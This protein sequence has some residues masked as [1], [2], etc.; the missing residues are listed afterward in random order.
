M[1]I[2]KS[3]YIIPKFELAPW[4]GQ[5]YRPCF[6]KD[7]EYGDVKCLRNVGFQPDGSL[8]NPY[9]AKCSGLTHSSWMAFKGVTTISAIREIRKPAGRAQQKTVSGTWGDKKQK[10]HCLVPEETNNKKHCLVPEETKNTVWYLRG[11]KTKNTVWYL[12]GQKTKNTVW[13]LRGQKTKKYCLV[14]EETKKTVATEHSDLLMLRRSIVWSSHYTI[15]QSEV[16][17]VNNWR[18]ISL[19]I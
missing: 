12:R 8:V 16:L 14:P 1:K 7:P 11:Q 18:V 13:Y 6:K 4:T 15:S 17:S 3:E 9:V 19:K 2:G 10:K 5:T